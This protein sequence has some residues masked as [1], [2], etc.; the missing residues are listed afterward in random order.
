[1]EVTDDLTMWHQGAGQPKGIHCLLITSEDVLGWTGVVF[2]I[3]VQ[4]NSI[5]QVHQILP[6]KIEKKPISY[7][8]VFRE[9]AKTSKRRNGYG[10][11]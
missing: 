3:F 1:M 8:N 4:T 6:R 9:P 10:N 2:H 5:L 7:L 11:N